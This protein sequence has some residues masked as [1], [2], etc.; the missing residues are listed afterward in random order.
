MPPIL[1]LGSTA[2]Q[3][4]VVPPVLR[5]EKV[6]ALAITEPCG[7]SDVAAMQTR[8]QYVDAVPDWDAALLCAVG[9]LAPHDTGLWSCFVLCGVA[10]LREMTSCSMAP[11]PS[12][13]QE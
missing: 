2:L 11:R 9:L 10:G 5:G 3:E 1:A 8:A 6:A 13:R 7:G 4:R 12:S